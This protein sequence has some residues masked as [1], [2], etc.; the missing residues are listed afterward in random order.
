MDKLHSNLVFMNEALRYAVLAY[1]QGE[2]PVGAVVVYRDEI[3]AGAHNA[4]I[5]FSDPTAHAE[6]LAMRE[7]GRY[8]D[9]YRLL[10]ADLFVTLEPCLM[11][12]SAMVH[13]RIRRLVY[14]A[15][16]KKTGYYSTGSFG[17]VG[18][19]FNHKI[20]KTE[21]ILA[22]KSSD[23]LKKFFKER[24]DAGAAERGGLENR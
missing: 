19:I 13:A 8:L 1:D 24:R 7:A 16:D 9:N 18:K 21:G 23:L 22:S 2:V 4:V 5:E 20:E 6:L 17:F 10:D 3:I 15:I 12:Y 11:C 14:G